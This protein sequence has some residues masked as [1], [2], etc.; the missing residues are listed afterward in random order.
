[1][2]ARASQILVSVAPTSRVVAL[3]EFCALVAGVCVLLLWQTVK[4]ACRALGWIA[5]DWAT[6]KEKKT[7]KKAAAL[8]A[9]PTSA[10][11][12][13]LPPDMWE[14]LAERIG[15]VGACQPRRVCKD[16]R[17][18]CDEYLS[19]L[20]GLVVCGGFG[21]GTTENLLRLHLATMRWEPMPALE[22]GR[23]HPACCAVRGALVVLGG[24]TT[25]GCTSSV[26]MLSSEGERAFVD[27]PPLSCG[28]IHGAGAIAVA[29]SDSAMGQVLLLGDFDGSTFLSSMH[30]VDMA[31]GACAQ[32]P[33]LLHRRG[34]PAA[35]RLPDGRVVC[36][37]GVG[38]E[39]SAEV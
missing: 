7:S 35:G 19:T 24:D 26:E 15:V 21:A 31:T 22:T 33:D 30:L 8:A 38:G 14:L 6:E 1:V 11:A 37:G 16:A 10:F 17:A 32:Q 27:L 36:A 9:A 28:G 29:E 13:C 34:Y 20:P 5:F 25:E 39:Q 12:P 23:Y 3:L 2:Q 18:G 4:F